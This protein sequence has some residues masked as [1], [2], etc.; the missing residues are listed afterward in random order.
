[1]GDSNVIEKYYQDK[2]LTGYAQD[3]GKRFFELC[4]YLDLKWDNPFFRI[5]KVGELQFVATNSAFSCSL[6]GSLQDRGKLI[7]P[8]GALE[9]AV[10]KLDGGRSFALVNHFPLT[11]FEEG[12]FRLVEPRVR[13]TTRFV[14]FGHVHNANPMAQRSA[15]SEVVYLQSG[16]LFARSDYFKGYSYTSID[17][18]HS[19]SLYRSYYDQRAV[20]DVATNVAKEGI[21]YPRP[22]DKAFWFQQSKKYTAEDLYKHLE[23][24]V[25]DHYFSNLN[26]AMLGM[27]LHQSYVFPTFGEVDLS[28]SADGGQPS[29]Q[30]RGEGDVKDV[31]DHFCCHFT[32]E[33]GATSFL[34]YLAMEYSASC[35][36]VRTPR[37]PIYVDIR[38][39]KGYPAIV[40]SMLKAGM[41]Q[42]EHP[43]FGWSARSG[44]QPYIILV[45]NFDPAAADHR[46]WLAEAY[47][48]VP[49]ARFV[50]C[51]KAPF[52]MH[53]SKV[54]AKIDL[55]FGH[56]SWVLYPFDRSEVRALVR[57][58]PLPENLDRDV[59]VEEIR[60]KFKT[61]GIPLTGPIIC[62][63]LTVLREKRK[64]A[65]INAAAV[66]ENFV[67]QSLGKGLSTIVYQDDFDYTEQLTI[68]C[69]CAEAYVIRNIECA[70]YSELYALIQ[71]YYR[72]RGMKRDAQAIVN[73]F[74]DKTIFENYGNNIYFRYRVVFSYL[75][76]RRMGEEPQFKSFILHEDRV[77]DF[78]SELDMYTGIH[79]GDVA[80]VEAIEKL[81]DSLTGDIEGEFGRY[82]D[83]RSVSKIKLPKA[84]K[85]EEFVEAMQDSIDEQHSPEQRD[86]EVEPSIEK[87]SQFVQRFK[88]PDEQDLLIRWAKLTACYS[89]TLKNSDRLNVVQKRAHLTKILNRWGMLTGLCFKVVSLLLENGKV[90]IGGFEMNFGAGKIKDPKMVRLI[91]ANV[92]QIVS[93]YTRMY[94]ASGKLEEIYRTVELDD[95]PEFLRVAGMTDLRMNEFIGEIS[96]YHK[97]YRSNPTMLESL[98]WK[99][100]DS[101][102]RFGLDKVFVQP[103]RQQIAEFGADILGKKGADRDRHVADT[104]QRLGEQRLTMK[105]RRNEE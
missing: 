34:L 9:D 14:F 52:A 31:D 64:Y 69:Y 17:G 57:K 3:L 78:I 44:D 29:E 65:P 95:F 101:F 28:K 45:D 47:R 103:M 99:M 33:T 51:A 76:A 40:L 23:G 49:K 30:H 94:V 48:L 84:S 42:V 75:I 59:I 105:L 62:M 8:L 100:R 53:G 11:D 46:R 18:D 86:A 93:Q 89:V 19:F 4:E 79:R 58:F 80:T 61:I 74:I 21:F 60:F 20:F 32:D 25:K 67:E 50:I 15:D 102:L 68:L 97:R 56:R 77:H 91:V 22:A 87:P 27:E 90:K 10:S 96:R 7:Y 82:V 98:M 73:H 24:L 1:M 38:G 66:I 13:S 35:R 71:E 12:N 72:H 104:I 54:K 83:R 70:E 39:T 55:P 36:K 5:S 63:Y 85:M 43:V 37:I 88:R 26:L 16:A 41:P 81:H 6:E 92:P 2:A